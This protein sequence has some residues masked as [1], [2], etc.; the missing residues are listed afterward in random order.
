MQTRLTSSKTKGNNTVKILEL[1]TDG[2]T[3]SQ[4]ARALKLSRTYVHKV[5]E[6]AVKAGILT[7]S[8]VYPV[9]YYWSDQDKQKDV[10]HQLKLS[11]Q[12]PLFQLHKLG[13]SYFI[14]TAVDEW[15]GFKEHEHNNWSQWVKREQGMTIV[16]FKNK[17]QFWVTIQPKARM[18]KQLEYAKQ[19]VNIR[20]QEI[21][22]QYNTRLI[23]DRPIT[24]PDAECIDKG[25]NTLLV[26]E[27]NV[28]QKP[29]QLGKAELVVDRSHVNPEI[30]GPETLDRAKA[31]RFFAE[32]GMDYLLT[33]IERQNIVL[34]S[35]TE[36][37]DAV[38][39]LMKKETK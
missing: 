7:R 12:K 2:A 39:Y 15:P 29:I 35:I 13:Y 38:D 18:E 19:L 3:K 32:E 9:M 1:L 22:Q 6:K 17:I 26:N 21:A 11:A 10:N 24:S 8:G 27:M 28:K 16:A 31:L 30:R 25:I 5:A 37:Q 23:F 20:A 14:Y 33:I 34:K 36:I 4:T